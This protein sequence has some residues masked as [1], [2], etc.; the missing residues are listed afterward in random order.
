[1]PLHFWADERNNPAVMLIREGFPIVISSDDPSSWD[2]VGL[3]FDFYEAF[4]GLAGRDMDLRLL[5]RFVFD[6][7]KYSALQPEAKQ[8][9]M[10][11][12]QVKW[13]KFMSQSTQSLKFL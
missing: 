8:Q 13:D 7:V 9:C 12:V 3:S 2:S 4:M 10:Q 6:S 1:M 11:L 5:K